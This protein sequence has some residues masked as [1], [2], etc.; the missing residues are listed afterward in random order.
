MSEPGQPDPSSA[1]TAGHRGTGQPGAL[2]KAVLKD[3]R[4]EATRRS[5]A[6]ADLGQVETG[7]PGIREKQAEREDVWSEQPAS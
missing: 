4:G 5:I 3:A 2:K 1:G 6:G 7:Q